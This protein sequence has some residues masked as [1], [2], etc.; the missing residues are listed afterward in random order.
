[1]V[2]TL[3]FQYQK[4][5]KT[6]YKKNTKLNTSDFHEVVNEIPMIFKNLSNFGLLPAEGNATFTSSKQRPTPIEILPYFCRG[7]F[8][9]LSILVV[10]GTEDEKTILELPGKMREVLLEQEKGRIMPILFKMD[11]CIANP[12]ELNEKQ[13]LLLLE[14]F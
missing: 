14:R 6:S 12:K 11:Q 5:R 10:V 9:G 2:A 7:Y 3:H 8:E 13:R 1:M 4:D